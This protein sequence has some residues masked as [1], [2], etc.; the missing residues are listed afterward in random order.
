MPSR[1]HRSHL[2][3]W[4]EEAENGRLET[5]E[6]SH[7]FTEGSVKPAVDKWKCPSEVEYKPPASKVGVVHRLG[8]LQHRRRFRFVDIREHPMF[9]HEMNYDLDCE[10]SIDSGDGLGRVLGEQERDAEDG[11][12]RRRSPTLR[13]RVLVRRNKTR[14]AT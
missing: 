9:D 4:D 10:I 12:S 2:H 7:A 3:Q 8:R 5:R 6:E 13:R 1:G 14:R 11:Q